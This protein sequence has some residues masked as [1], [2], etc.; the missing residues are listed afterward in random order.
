MPKKGSDFE[1][2]PALPADSRALDPK[3][4]VAEAFVMLC[5]DELYEE[6]AAAADTELR[7]S[8]LLL[9]YSRLLE[10]ADAA[11][12]EIEKKT[13]LTKTIAERVIEDRRERKRLEEV[14][15]NGWHSV[16]AKMEND[17]AV[18]AGLK[19]AKRSAA[20]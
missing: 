2:R 5:K 9:T 3:I 12:A 4:V 20:A 11:R 6:A 7:D 18:R 1:K 19:P 8:L 13:G 17:I 10:E 16:N 15:G 14:H